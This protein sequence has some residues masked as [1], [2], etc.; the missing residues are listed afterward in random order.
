[1][2]DG[3]LLEEHNQVSRPRKKIRSILISQPR[4]Q[5]SP[6]FDLEDKFGV[7]VDFRSF[8]QVEPVNAKDFRKQKVY[9]EEYTAIIF[10]SLNAVD[11]FFRLAEEMR[12]KIHPD[13][14]YFCLTE[15]IANYLQKFILLRKRKVFSGNKVIQDLKNPLNKHKDK[16]KFLLPCSN[17]GSQ[18]VTNYLKELKVPFQEAMMYQ[19]VSADLS[20]L[21]DIF[22]DIL[23][24]FSPIDLKSLYDNFPD[25]KQ[26]DT[27][28]ATYGESTTKAAMDYGLH[29][30]VKAPT[31][32]LPSMA[33]ALEYF[34]K[35]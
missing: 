28:I 32:E 1:M 3:Q 20:D 21:R 7:K 8:I 14:K 24:F 19:T 16:E 2:Q 9:P 30:H 11:N 17:L 18:D 27:C 35:M 29:I 23:V 33:M 10:T 12:V 22:Y 26:N 34:L 31:P 25:F 13:L 6:Y 4:P 5:R 15:N